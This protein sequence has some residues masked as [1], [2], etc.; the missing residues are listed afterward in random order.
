M[1][2]TPWRRLVDSTP[3]E[4]EATGYVLETTAL[5]SNSIKGHPETWAKSLYMCY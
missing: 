5:G 3:A 1:Y 4:L 2:L